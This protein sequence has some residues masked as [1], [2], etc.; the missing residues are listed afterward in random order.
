M[1]GEELADVVRRRL[2]AAGVKR[3]DVVVQVPSLAVVVR[4]QVQSDGEIRRV[5]RLLQRDGERPLLEIISRESMERQL[6]QYLSRELPD[7][8]ASVADNGRT[9]IR[10]RIALRPDFREWLAGNVIRDIPGV[11]QVVYEA[12]EYTPVQ[13]IPA[14]PYSI[15]QVGATRFLVGPKGGRMFPGAEISPGVLLDA[16]DA[17]AIAVVR[18]RD[19][20]P[21]AGT[22]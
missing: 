5:E 10:T 21:D 3:L 15:L 12:P 22:P 17:D 13:R 6:G 2:D 8:T 20:V 11:A 19:V 1:R 14:Q 4:G 18:A 16:V 9:T 7:A